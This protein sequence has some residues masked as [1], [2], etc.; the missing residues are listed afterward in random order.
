MCI[1]DRAKEVGKNDL[2]FSLSVLNG[3]VDNTGQVWV[4]SNQDIYL[5]EIT[6][7]KGTAIP[8]ATDSKSKRDSP[9][10]KLVPTVT[11]H[12][13]KH[14]LNMLTT[15][16]CAGQPLL[17]DPTGLQCLMDLKLYK[18]PEI[19]RPYQYLSLYQKRAAE[20]ETFSYQDDCAKDFNYTAD[21]LNVLLTYV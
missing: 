1:R 19:Q 20:L 14:V 8:M 16:E 9:F 10:Y 7:P 2:L 3:I 4:C 13:P 11:C 21:C 5:P 12:S 18:S 6:L 15:N 17:K